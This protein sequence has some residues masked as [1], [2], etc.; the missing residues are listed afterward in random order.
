MM[1]KFQ[2]H[3]NDEEI[4]ILSIQSE[5]EDWEDR[6]VII[7]EEIDFFSNILGSGLKETVSVAINKEDASYLK[8]QLEL[9]N[10]ANEF[11]LSTFFDYKNKLEGLKECDDV[12]CENFYLKDHLVFKTTLRKHFK[13]FRQ[14]K[15]LIFKFLKVSFN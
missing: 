2:E 7:S 1:E 9:I 15:A 4:Q 8:K 3:H 14:L 12:Q 6:L 11:H 10:K 5:S 13:D